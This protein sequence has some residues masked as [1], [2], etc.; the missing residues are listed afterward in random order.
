MVPQVSAL[1]ALLMHAGSFR[2][3]SALPALLMRAGSFRDTLSQWASASHVP[4]NFGKIMKKHAKTASPAVGGGVG[5][6]V[7]VGMHV[8]VFSNVVKR[9]GES[10]IVCLAA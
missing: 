9:K 8:H 5:E 1:P 4:R 6:Q 3:M 10:V 7:G 2:D